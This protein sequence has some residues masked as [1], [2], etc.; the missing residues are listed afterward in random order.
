[1]LSCTENSLNEISDQDTGEISLRERGGRG[2][3]GRGV[4]P[5]LIDKDILIFD[6]SKQFFAFYEYLDGVYDQGEEIYD[7]T[8]SQ[9]LGD[10]CLP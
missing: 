2:E 1:M 4:R 7:A 3:D 10:F 8:V 6:D 5:P 9:L